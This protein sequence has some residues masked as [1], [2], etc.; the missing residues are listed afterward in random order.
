MTRLRTALAVALLVLLPMC[1][2]FAHTRSM[3]YSHWTFDESGV[4]VSFKI[5]LLELSRFPS[6]IPDASYFAEVLTLYS[7]DDVLPATEAVRMVT[8]PDGWARFRWRIPLD[9]RNDLLIRSELLRDVVSEHAHLIRIVGYR[10]N[11]TTLTTER[12]LTYAAPAWQLAEDHP[13]AQGFLS[14]IALGIRHILSGY[15]HLAFVLCLLLLATTFREVA[16]LITGFTVA[17]SITLALAV[18]GWVRPDAIGVEILIAFSIALIAVENLWLIDGKRGRGVP[19]GLLGA[20]FAGGILS[21]KGIG[22]LSVFT[23]TALALFC[24]CHLQLLRRSNRP[25]ALRTLLT[26]AFGLIHGLGFAGVLLEME[27]PA[28]QRLT[29][30]LGFNTGVELGQLAVVLLLWPVLWLLLRQPRSSAHRYF[31]ELGS[32]AMLALGLYWF[33]MRNWS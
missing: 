3:S 10:A 19:A 14:F 29:A 27:L 11:D 12:V 4:T 28:P 8:A 1:S 32:T 15:D 17:H 33:I 13:G 22:H 23:W 30:L 18:V 6:G 21:L 24:G 5:T 16:W 25:N 26:F 7:G 9:D 31:A 2:A 20:L